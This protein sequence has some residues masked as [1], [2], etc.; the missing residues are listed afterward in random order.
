MNF[1]S[2]HKLFL[3]SIFTV[4]AIAGVIVFAVN[5][6][7]DQSLSSE[8]GEN[9]TV[10]S[11]NPG[12]NLSTYI[13]VINGCGPY[14]TDECLNVRSG[15]GTEYPSI[16]KLRTGIVLNV[17]EKITV[18]GME[19]YKITFDDEWIRYTDRIT[20]DWYVAAQYVRAFSDEGLVELAPG[21]IV[22]TDKRIV[23]DRS[24]Q[25]LYAYDGEKL[26]MKQ[27]TS[28]GVELTPTPHGEFKVYK[29]MPTRYMQ[30]PIPEVTDEY[31]DLPGVPWNLYFTKLGGAIHG[32][33]WHDEFGQP[34]SHG[35]VNL[36][37]EEAQ[38]LYEWA[39]LGTPVIVQE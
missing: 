38:K 34:R 27:P 32:A 19:W 21:E 28:T 23:V 39:D 8:I 35:C 17:E 24:E 7:N 18:N 5:V 25:M 16:L 4:L 20:T 37:P 3:F 10:V 9:E 31:Y 36:P 15:P 13:K 33:Y 1:T 29:K 22:T 6:E 26:F 11:E 14:W 30:G 12:E 2:N